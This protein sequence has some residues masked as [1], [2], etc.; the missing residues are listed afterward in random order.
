ME[1]HPVRNALHSSH[2]LQH[3]GAEDTLE[4]LTLIRLDINE[5]GY[6]ESGQ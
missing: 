3:C 5:V 1:R 4:A 6:R 2:S